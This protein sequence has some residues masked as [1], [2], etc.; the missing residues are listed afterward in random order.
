[1]TYEQSVDFINENMVSKLGLGRI[2]QLLNEMDNPQDDIKC[3]H[4]TGTNGKGSVCDMVKSILQSQGYKVGIFTSPYLVSINESVKVNDDF[5]SNDDLS[6]IVS[7]IKILVNSMTDTPTEF[8][9]LT[10][11]AFEHFKREKCDFA[12]IEIG[13]GGRL[14]STNVIKSPLI[15]VITDV[16]IDHTSYLGTTIE[17]I[18]FEKAGIIKQDRPVVWGGRDETAKRVI[19]EK[20]KCMNSKITNVNYSLTNNES[21]TLNGCSFDY[22]NL[23]K[24]HMNVLGLY[25]ITNAVTALTV[26]SL[27][28]GTGICISDKAVYDGLESVRRRGRFERILGDVFYDGAHNKSG[29]DFAVKSIKHYFKNE[30]V[31]V[32]M[33]VMADKDYP[34]MVSKI[35]EVCNRAF[36]VTPSN[37]RSLNAEKLRDEFK[38]YNIHADVCVNIKSGVISAIEI[39]KTNNV[40]L[41]ILGSLYMY[42]DIIDAVM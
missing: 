1:M 22:G 4:V 37:P 29:I 10:A 20:A 17:E 21:L 16:A 38:K 39:S 2:K 31:N 27:M 25:Q 5:I 13:M 28:R 24:L 15:S 36:T 41:F 30:K 12:V 42:G 26:I 11:M 23:K 9:I 8:E 18:A 7:Y 3:I 19:Y 32:L 33:G 40:P 35:S 34:Y 6:E 14:D